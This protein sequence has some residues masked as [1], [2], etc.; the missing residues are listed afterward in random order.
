M[1][2]TQDKQHI[3]TNFSK[4]AELYDQ[5]ASIQKEVAAELFLQGEKKFTKAKSVLDIGC[6][7]GYLAKFLKINYPHL[8]ITQIDIADEMVKKCAKIPGTKALLADMENL[9][10]KDNEFNMSISSLALQWADLKKALT[11]AKRVTSDYLLLNCLTN[12]SFNELKDLNSG[13]YLKPLPEV[14]EIKNIADELQINNLI[15]KTV[16]LKKEYASFQEF[17]KILKNIGAVATHKKSKYLGKNFFKDLEA[18]Y[19]ATHPH[20]DKIL[21]SWEVTFIKN[22]S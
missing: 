15:V 17:F 1:S 7:T 19:F 3:A 18:K 9:P 20:T 12:N 13:I 5:F 6:G 16:T 14:A 22:F 4:Q 2:S 11:E 21:L 8:A 10:F